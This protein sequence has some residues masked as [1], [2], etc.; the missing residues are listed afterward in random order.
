MNETTI[1]QRSVVEQKIREAGGIV[2]GDGN[3]FFTNVEVFQRAIAALAGAAQAEPVAWLL[4]DENINSLQ[5][6]SVQ[7]LIE[8]S[9]HASRA[10]VKLRING[11]DEWYEAD[12][13][14]H[15]TKANTAQPLVAIESWQR[16]AQRLTRWLHCMSYNDSYFGEPAGLVKQVTAELNR[17]L[18]TAP[19]P[20]QP[21]AVPYFNR[22]EVEYAIHC[23]ENPTGMCLNDNKERV[24]LPGGTL[25]RMLLII[26]MLSAA[27]S[28]SAGG[29]TS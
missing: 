7:K 20:A 6:A 13:M 22:R 2:H 8:R 26:D 9:R 17:L 25:R 28:S 27:P 5:V 15:M 19:Q 1:L 14:K 24:A 29:E 3:I 4:T 10:D 23:A 12:W 11:Q 18:N 16:H 21:V